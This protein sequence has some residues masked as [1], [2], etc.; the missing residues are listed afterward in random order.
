MQRQRKGED[1]MFIQVNGEA[2]ELATAIS[3]TA[4][5]AG[6]QLLQ[7]KLVIEHNG[8]I[9]PATAWPGVILEAGDCL[10]IVT[11]VGGG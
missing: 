3:L 8:Q 9:V 6:K 4:W 11:F 2:E 7:Q 5:L 10:E 1:A